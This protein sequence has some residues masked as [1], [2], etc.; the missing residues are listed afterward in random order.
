M[1]LQI[2]CTDKTE[3]HLYTE[4]LEDGA[5]QREATKAVHN[6]KTCSLFN[7]VHSWTVNFKHGVSPLVTRSV[8]LNVGTT[9]AWEKSKR[10]KNPCRHG[11]AFTHAGRRG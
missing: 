3:Q 8:H 2:T 6:R 7:D 1:L 11:E 10:K 9:F 5:N 4:R